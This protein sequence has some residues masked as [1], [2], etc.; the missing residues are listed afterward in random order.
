MTDSKPRAIHWFFAHED[1]VTSA[2]FS[3][4]GQTLATGGYDCAIRL[5]E[6]G[7]SNEIQALSGHRRG[8][9]AFSPDGK[10][11][12]SGGLHK[13]ATVYDT[14]TWL[15]KRTLYQ[16][17][18]IWDLAF[19]SDGSS[20][21]ITQPSDSLDGTGRPIEIRN[22]STWRLAEIAGV[23]A[24]NV[25]AVAFS[26]D[27][28]NVA[29]VTSEKTVSVWDSAFASK[30][31][32]FTAHELATWGLAFSPD[33]ATLATGGADNMARLWDTATWSVK[34]E[35]EH[36]PMPDGGGYKNAVLCTA[37]SPD[38]A[39]LVTGGLDGQV[40]VWQF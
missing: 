23:G 4:D 26:P 30:Q 21:A 6:A 9:V 34:Y 20:V 7:T 25:D 27:G 32:E 15:P 33:S 40:T 38:G 13:N 36:K 22:T 24:R 14:A 2:S 1:G 5:W 12:V 16:T 10:I 31:A 3:P 17:S 19:T 11:L 28:K 37:F 39:V 18:G 29:I 8:H 35:L